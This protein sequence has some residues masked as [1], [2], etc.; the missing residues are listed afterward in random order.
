MMVVHT[1]FRTMVLYEDL[2]PKEGCREKTAL[3]W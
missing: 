3:D 2:N 1:K